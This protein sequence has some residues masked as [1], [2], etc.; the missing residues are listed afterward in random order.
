MLYRAFWRFTGAV[1]RYLV[2]DVEDAFEAAFFPLGAW[3]FAGSLI[4][5]GHA[6]ET[7]TGYFAIALGVAIA[8]IAAVWTAGSVWY[9]ARVYG[10]YPEVRA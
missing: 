10:R 1:S 8:A 4:A 2:E 5:G 3:A 9:F 7:I 6:M